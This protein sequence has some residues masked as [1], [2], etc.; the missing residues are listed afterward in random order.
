MGCDWETLEPE[1]WVLD[2]MGTALMHE[3]SCSN[4]LKEAHGHVKVQLL[5][6]VPERMGI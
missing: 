4:M 6:P 5:R 1:V 3:W 2:H